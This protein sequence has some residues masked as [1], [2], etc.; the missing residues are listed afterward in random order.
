MNGRFRDWN[1]SL[2]A[3][4]NKIYDGRCSAQDVVCDVYFVRD[5]VYT[6]INCSKE[7]KQNK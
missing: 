5:C 4:H 2:Q 7:E 3:D 6:R 1:A